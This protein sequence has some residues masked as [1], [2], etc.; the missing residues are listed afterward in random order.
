MPSEVRESVRPSRIEQLRVRN[1]RA[2]NDVTF[3]DL[4]SLTVLLGPNGS[5]KSTVFDVFGFLSE[6]FT[7]GLRRAWDKRLRGG[8]LKTRGSE[9]PVVIEL[10]Y[11]DGA[12]PGRPLIT[13]HLAIDDGESGPVVAKES[14]AWRR[15]SHGRPFTFLEF[16]YGKGTA[17][18]GDVPESED[19]RTAQELRSPDLIAVNTLGQFKE[20]VRVAALRDFVTG[21]YVSYLSVDDA[22]GQPEVGPEE[23]LDR[24]G[25]NLANVVQYLA[26]RH[27]DR[28]EEIFERLRSRV[29]HLERA[30]ARPMQDGRLLLA[31]KDAPFERPI[32][33][34]FASDGTLKLLAYLIALHDPDPPP[35][36][37]IEEPE[38]FLHPRLPQGLA[39]ECRVASDRTQLFVT[40]HAPHFLN[41]VRPDEAWVLSRDAEGHTRASR[42]S[43][44]TGVRAFVDA[45]ATLGDLW[46]EG[47]LERS[48]ADAVDGPAVHDVAPMGA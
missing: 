23:R 5:G 2:L 24:T 13:Y 20:H 41:G 12:V 36:I 18:R 29:P 26:E 25:S 14:L 19:Q 37:G 10:K 42:A 1:Y 3:R 46:M 17:V 45:G 48:D 11:R 7:D 27:P 34:K 38:N 16:Q 21:W 35:F 33:S 8:E 39:E 4:S 22:R 40:T 43:D 44:V 28:L 30:I 31:F 6:C 47:H 15:H 32:L 9:G